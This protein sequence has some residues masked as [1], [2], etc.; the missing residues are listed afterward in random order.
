MFNINLFIQIIIHEMLIRIEP[1]QCD[2]M[3]E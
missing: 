1:N 2:Q 3:W